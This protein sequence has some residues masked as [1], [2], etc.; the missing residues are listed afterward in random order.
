ML[1]DMCDINKFCGDYQTRWVWNT[2]RASGGD[3]MGAAGDPRQ[4]GKI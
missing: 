2:R 3:H 4:T 1:Y